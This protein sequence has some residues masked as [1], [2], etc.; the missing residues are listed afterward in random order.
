MVVVEGATSAACRDA[1][2]RIEANMSMIIRVSRA[3][4]RTVTVG[5]GF[6]RLFPFLL[7]GFR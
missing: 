2:S 4:N 1:G 5:W 7:N 6:I 3:L